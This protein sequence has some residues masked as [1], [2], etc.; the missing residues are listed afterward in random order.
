MR[1]LKLS[2]NLEVAG[3]QALEKWLRSK[4]DPSA[5]N[6]R[7][8][9]IYLTW[10]YTSKLCCKFDFSKVVAKGLLLFGDFAGIFQGRDKAN[11]EKVAI[12]RV[13][14]SGH[15]SDSLLEIIL[16]KNYLVLYVLKWSLSTITP[17]LILFALPYLSFN[18]LVLV[19]QFLLS[20][21]R[22]ILV[23][24][25]L[26]HENVTKLRDVIIAK[27]TKSGAVPS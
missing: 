5:S 21:L 8:E 23:L 16:Y 19:I 25:N 9:Q 18:V 20:A 10:D 26:Q 7:F 4:L 1:P 3:R 17:L 27:D 11:D 12:K 22:E 6:G 2:I 14:M 15:V 24:K 13:K